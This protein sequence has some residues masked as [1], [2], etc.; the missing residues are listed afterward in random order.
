MSDPVKIFLAGEGKNELGGRIGPAAF[1][2][3][4][5]RGVLEALLQNIRANG[6]N[7]GGAREWKSFRHY[8][9]KGVVDA[10]TRA[11]MRAALDAREANCQVLVFCRDRDKDEGRHDA[12]EKGI[13]RVVSDGNSSLDVIGGLAIPTLEGWILALLAHSQTDLLSP[14]RAAQNLVAAGVPAKDTDAM[15]RVVDDANLATLPMEAESLRRWLDRA[16]EAM[17]RH[18]H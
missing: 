1:H 7:I 2:K 13:Q 9:V 10:E 8:K 5:K 15:V 3:P 14:T 11:V 4:E 16:R 17:A 6:W 18:V 12:I